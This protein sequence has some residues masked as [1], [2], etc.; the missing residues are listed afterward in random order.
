MILV[1]G[2]AEEWKRR[3]LSFGE[4][5]KDFI[6]FIETVDIGVDVGN[7]PRVLY[8]ESSEPGRQRPR[9]A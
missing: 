4:A 6:W 7:Y 2:D 9:Q 8:Q 1:D 5:M 3:A